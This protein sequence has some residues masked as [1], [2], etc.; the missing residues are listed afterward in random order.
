MSNE[1]K[2]PKCG[3]GAMR[4]QGMMSCNWRCEVCGNKIYVPRP[5]MPKADLS[6]ARKTV[7]DMSSRSV[8]QL[9]RGVMDAARDVNRYREEHRRL[10]RE[11][12]MAKEKAEILTKH[13]KRSE[14]ILKKYGH[15]S[16]RYRA[17]RAKAI[18]DRDEALRKHEKKWSRK[19]GGF[20]AYLAVAVIV[21]FILRYLG[22]V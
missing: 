22:I 10:G 6:G 5:E 13:A 3:I 12:D 20:F 14:A 21:L 2:C 8:D 1:W 7:S 16:E 11:A 9:S 4:Q 17:E 18:H 19:G 15:D